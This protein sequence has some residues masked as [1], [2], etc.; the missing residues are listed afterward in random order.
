MGRQPGFFD[1]DDR[2]AE[3]SETGDPLER[4]ASVVDFEV[5][6]P[7]LD[8][9]LGR[10]D[11]SKGGRPPMD[12][13]LMFKVLVLQALYGMSDE[14]AEFQ[15]RDRLTFMRFLG[16]GLGD[17]VPD[18]STI[19]R[20]REALVEADAIE[21]L[22]ARFDVELKDRGYF[23]LGGQVIDAS[24]VEAPKQRLT[25]DEKA[26]IK[27]GETAREIWP[28]RPAK[29][30]HKDTAAR[31]TVKRGQKKAKPGRDTINAPLERTAEGLMI[32][33]FGYKNH[34]NVDRRY[35]L[36]RRWTVSHAAA[37]DG[38]R[39]PD[40]LDPEA[41]ASGVWADTAYRSKANEAAIRGAGRRSMVHFKK[42]KGRPMPGPKQRANRARSKVRSSVEH[43]FADQKNRMGLFVR[44]IGMA[45]AKTKIGLANLVHNMRRLIWLESRPAPA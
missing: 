14:Q 6:R 44:T 12:A 27:A 36:I 21:G 45:R 18:Y 10:S 39:L 13:V 35:R 37:H 5:F 20:F 42:P 11:R 26:R 17:R 30:A 29:A 33:V 19:W 41:F 31:W 24:I 4:L 25:D 7:E 28:A 34:V 3:L 15:I 22:F 9:V 43:V 2:Y 32:P 16:L 23:A 40:L 8:R 38:A 1:L